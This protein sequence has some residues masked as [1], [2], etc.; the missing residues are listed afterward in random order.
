MLIPVLRTDGGS[1]RRHVTQTLND[2]HD[3]GSPQG[4]QRRASPRDNVR[5]Q[6]THTGQP[7]SVH[8]APVVRTSLRGVSRGKQFR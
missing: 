8:N 3:G 4:V 5:L 2:E 1:A 6:N 7:P